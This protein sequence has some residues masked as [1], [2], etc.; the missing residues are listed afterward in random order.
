MRENCRNI[1]SRN[2]YAIYIFSL[3][4]F[5]SLTN[6]NNQIEKNNYLIENILDF[7]IYS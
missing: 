7:K 4:Y 5:I 2:C 6:S 1:Y 3:I